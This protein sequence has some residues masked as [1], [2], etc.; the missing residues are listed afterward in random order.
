MAAVS[1]N[2]AWAQLDPQLFNQCFNLWAEPG[3]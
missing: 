3:E 2:K 1:G